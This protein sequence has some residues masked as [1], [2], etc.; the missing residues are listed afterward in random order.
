MQSCTIM[1]HFVKKVIA[2]A[3]DP[4]G[5]PRRGKPC[6]SSTGIGLDALVGGAVVE[7]FAIVVVIEWLS[8]GMEE[9]MSGIG[10]V[11]LQEVRICVFGVLVKQ[12]SRGP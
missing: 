10:N 11:P 1:M 6:V 8:E 12:P 4:T 2:K 7:K 3:V 9:V 5:W